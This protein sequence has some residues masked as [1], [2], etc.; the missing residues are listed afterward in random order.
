MCGSTERSMS[1]PRAVSDARLFRRATA[2]LVCA[3]AFGASGQERPRAAEPEQLLAVVRANGVA[4]GEFTLVRTP[5]GDFWVLESELSRLRVT[6]IAA[7]RRHV[8]SDIYYSLRALGARSL[9]FDE[10]NV[11]LEVLFQTDRMPSTLIDLSPRPPS[12]PPTPPNASLILSYRLSAHNGPAAG[13]IP[14]TL[15]TDLN[16]QVRGVLLRQELRID[17][18]AH[19]SLARG[20]TQAIWDDRHNARRVVAG[21]LLSSAGPY[22][23]GIT[24]AGVLVAKRFEL[25]PEVIRQ[26]TASIRAAAALPAEVEVAVDGSPVYRTRVGPGPIDINNLLLYGGARDIRV[27]V[28]DASGRREVF[29]QPFLFTD[30]LLAAGL[31]DYSYFV[32][33]RS[34]LAAGS[35]WTY[36]EAAWQAYHRYGV[37]DHVTVGAG[38]EGSRDFTNAGAGITLRSDRLGVASLDLL[39]SRDRA[40]GR[41]AAGWSGRYS[42]VTPSWSLQVGHRQFQDGFR[43]FLTGPAN[44][45]PRRESRVAAST[46][47]WRGNIGLEW[48][49]L[50]DALETRIQRILRLGA[51]ITRATSVIAEIQSNRINGREE[52]SAFMFLRTELGDG[53]WAGGSLR[54]SAGLRSANV[55]AG[56]Q[57]YSGEGVGYRV[58][59]DAAQAGGELGS[60]GS[61]SVNWHLRPFTIDFVGS[62]PLT[63]GG[64]PFAA[65]AVAGAL[66]AV[67]GYWGLTRQVS[68]GFVL[69]RLGVPQSG[70]DVLLNNQ[71]QGRTDARGELFIPQTTAFVAQDVSVNDK[72]LGIQYAL[73]DRRRTIS[74]GYRSGTV[75]HFGGRKLSAIAGTAALRKDG[76]KIPIASRSWRMA[77]GATTVTIETAGAGDF[78][79][80]D[81]QPGEYRGEIVHDGVAYRCRMQVPQ[82]EEP[83]LELKEGIVCE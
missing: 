22:G 51:N 66:V 58:S 64:R 59:L 39:G 13:A 3:I 27:T 1:I 18:A 29:E 69:A 9:K 75:V 24:A 37:N 65:V 16:V 49:R 20:T 32:G 60:A 43:T 5:D 12:A 10:A 19:R 62:S 67:D 35:G 25:T 17:G 34:E 6:P 48:V 38:G 53:R 21:D 77:A 14:A 79:V 45:F 31:H 56:R 8:G 83:V 68:D 47:L 61:A 42:Y 76:R 23:S 46:R 4:Q 72:Q 41:L 33:R 55:E 63:G 74:P 7:A 70:V 81:A 52:H 80:E 26:P 15:E 2:A 40:A 50:E 71:L 73:A 36:R 54:S 57:V 28:T 78:Y 44:P 30:T 82:F 11:E